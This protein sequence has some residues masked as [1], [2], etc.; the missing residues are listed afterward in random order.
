MAK[1]NTAVHRNPI[2]LRLRG[3]AGAD[4]RAHKMKRKAV[5]HLLIGIT[6]AVSCICLAL[7]WIRDRARQSV[8]LSSQESSA[9]PTLILEP[10][11]LILNSADAPISL[12]V[13]YSNSSDRVMHVAPDYVFAPDNCEFVCTGLKE[14]P[15]V[16]YLDLN[17]Q[18]RS[19]ELPI[20][21]V[22]ST[23][24]V[25]RLSELGRIDESLTN[26]VIYVR[27]SGYERLFGRYPIRT[28]GYVAL[29]EKRFVMNC[30]TS[31]FVEVRYFGKKTPDPS[32]T[33]NTHSPSAQG[34]GGR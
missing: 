20:G 8:S 27:Q 17:T 1:V 3:P 31:N 22:I 26:F 25:I 23:N 7:I 15:L 18:V 9:L 19:M 2:R 13:T 4:G 14:V 28:D 32:D 12:T 11:S 30:V 34:A 33:P 10:R 29:R 6:V 16:D 24:M 5:K 21:N